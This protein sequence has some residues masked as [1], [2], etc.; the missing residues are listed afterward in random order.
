MDEFL[1]S[2][3]L[4]PGSIGPT[5]P[6]MQPFQFPTGPTGNTGPTGSTGFTGATGQTG[7][8][9]STGFTGV[10]GPTGD[11]GLTGITGPTGIT[12]TTGP[13]GIGTP[14][15]TGP[16]G[17]AGT[18]AYGSMYDL[19]GLGAFVQV[20]DI[21]DFQDPGQSSGTIL[22]LANNTIQVLTAGVY[23]IT[24]DLDISLQVFEEFGIVQFQLFINGVTPVIESTI[25]AAL[26]SLGRPKDFSIFQSNTI[27]KTIQI[28][29]NANDLLSIHVVVVSGIASYRSPSFTVIKIA[30]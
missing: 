25:Q 3:A 2:A 17:P 22:N 9:G 19:F 10:T 26:T 24:M 30:E 20:G 1:S 4:N 14:G 13:T 18:L 11:T 21:V 12:G 8:T 7:P 28:R 27:G 6:P 16:T 15:P 29:L 5:L 23:S